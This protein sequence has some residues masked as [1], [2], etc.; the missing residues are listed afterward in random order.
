VV[1]IPIQAA[2]C[3]AHQSGNVLIVLHP[4]GGLPHGFSLH[5][6]HAQR[7]GEEMIQKAEEARKVAPPK[8]N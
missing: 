4:V 8:A 2:E 6:D 1:A 3:D 7:L 5:P